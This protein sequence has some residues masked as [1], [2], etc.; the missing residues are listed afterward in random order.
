MDSAIVQQHKFK[1]NIL[2]W[3]NPANKHY[4]KCRSPNHEIKDYSKK[5]PSNPYKPLY[6]HFKPEQYRL[7]RPRIF[8][9]TQANFSYADAIKSKSSVYKNQSSN[10]TTNHSI[11]SLD[12]SDIIPT[13]ISKVKD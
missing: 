4:R 13:L 2:H 3:M 7:S 12:H 8:V 1:G 5:G 9:N 6:D 11:P 10:T